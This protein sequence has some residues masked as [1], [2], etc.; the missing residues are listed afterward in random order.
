MKIAV[1]E[2]GGAADLAADKSERFTCSESLD[3]VHRL[4]AASQAVLVGRGT[5][6]ADNPSLTIRRIPA[7]RQPLRV[8]L[9]PHGSL[10]DEWRNYQLFT[11]GWKT[12]VFYG[13]GELDTSNK[14]LPDSVTFV[15]APLLVQGSDHKSLSVTAIVHELS[16]SFG[17][18]DLMVEGGPATARRFLDEKLIDRCLIV[19]APISFLQPLDAGL[20]ND[21]L[22][23]AGLQ[24]LGT[25]PSGV[26]AIDYWSRPELPWPTRE[27]TEWP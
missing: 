23:Q 19:R 6:V 11:D 22:E 26:D 21:A 8:V 16:K 7:E 17:V 14:D 15:P 1:D 9:D 18:E 3:M 20:T 24:Y 4:R 2:N 12:V 25:A 13:E 10:L 5:V 27:L